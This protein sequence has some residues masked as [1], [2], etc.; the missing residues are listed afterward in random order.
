MPRVNHQILP[1]Y[2]YINK[3]NWWKNNIVV[4]KWIVRLKET[5]NGRKNYRFKTKEEAI[6]FLHKL[7]FEY[8]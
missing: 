1:T 4:Y 7:G 2:C 3:E 5:Y 6:D 8:E